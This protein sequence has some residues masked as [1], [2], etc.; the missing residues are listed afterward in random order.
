MTVQQ[1]PGD[2]L[3]RPLFSF[4]EE[5]L[6]ITVKN[7]RFVNITS[8]KNVTS[9]KDPSSMNSFNV[10]GNVTVTGL[11]ILNCKL[12]SSGLLKISG[13][14]DGIVTISNSSFGTLE[15]SPLNAQCGPIM[16]AHT[17]FSEFDYIRIQSS[18]M[19]SIHNCN[20]T[21]GG[22]LK[23]DADNVTV[24]HS[25]FVNNTVYSKDYSAPG[26][27]LYI[28]SQDYQDGV[29]GRDDADYSVSDCFFEGNSNQ[30]GGLQQGNVGMGGG[31]MITGTRYSTGET[32]VVKNCTF[33][34]NSAVSGGGLGTWGVANV[35]ISGCTFQQN[36]AS[37]GT[38]AAIYS[39]GL[40]NK[41]SSAYIEDSMVDDSRFGS[42][43]D[44]NCDVLLQSCQCAGVRTSHFLNSF[45]TGLCIIDVSG[46]SCSDDNRETLS[47]TKLHHAFRTW[48]VSSSEGPPLVQSDGTGFIGETNLVN[49]LQSSA[50][51]YAQPTQFIG[52]TNVVNR[53]VVDVRDCVFSNHTSFP[54]FSADPFVGGAGLRLEFIAVAVLTRLAFM[55]NT[56]NQGGGLHLKA[57]DKTVL[58]DSHFS[59]NTAS[60]TGGGIAVVAPGQTGAE[61]STQ[62]GFLVG[63]TNITNCRALQGGGIFGG[64]GTSITISNVT[65]DSNV[66]GTDGGAVYCNGCQSCAV[67]DGSVVGRNL[68]S[69][70]GGGCFFD[71]SLLLNLTGLM[72]HDNR[73]T[74][75]L[76]QLLLFCCCADSDAHAASGLLYAC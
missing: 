66:A 72:M 29:P 21:S 70:S 42:A 5:A 38:G 12:I 43:N 41:L 35:L 63:G 19:V 30:G 1:N 7:S 22:Q 55:G 62:S 9:G 39:F 58:W 34:G 44:A 46:G 56:A 68:A 49:Q 3:E 17:S 60:Q 67:K 4:G 27:A 50:T 25:M 52:D 36:Y 13:S 48:G 37:S 20:F 18:D 14:R 40:Q 33:L 61:M 57:C 26:G 45:G 69:R 11:A 51:G 16:L 6:S 73:L 54:R 28:N 32:L 74:P 15:S 64:P 24:S 31:F 8:A 65:L 2:N 53:I 59:D 10:E 71:T 47:D 76:F 75:T 23:I